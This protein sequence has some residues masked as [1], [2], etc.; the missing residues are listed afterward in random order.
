[1]DWKTLYC[2]NP[3]CPFYGVRFGESRLVKNGTTRGQHQ[4]LC[5]ACGSSIA[6]TYGTPYFDLEHDP[7][8]FEL[9][10]RALAEGNS[11]R[12]TARIIQM[13]KDT[14]CIWLDRAAQQ[15]R[16]V[17]LYLWQQLPL[18]ECQLDELG[19][20]VHTKDEHL[21]WAKTYHDTYGDAWVWV[22]FAPE[23]RLV[24]AFVVGKRTQ[25]DANLL[26]E[27]VAHV[28]TDLIPFFTS[29]QLPEYR[30]ALLHVY[31]R[32]YQPPRCGTRGPHPQPRRVPHKE[33]RYAQVVKTRER[34][35]VVAV[36]HHVVFG[37]VQGIAT[38]LASLPT[39]ATINTS[40]V[41]RENLALRQHN[42]RLTRKTNAFS[43]EL[44]WLEKQ[45]W[46]SLAYTHLVLPHDSLGQ[47]LPMVEPTRGTGSPRRWQ[48]RTPAMAAGLTDHVWT[49]D[50]LLSYR[51]PARFVDQL[52]QLEHLFP[53]PELICQ[54][55]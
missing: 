21:A 4:A 40:F 32:W 35:R 11:I 20:F 31:G 49:T 19:S 28:T 47:A 53:Q 1:M 16:L 42:R 37:D 25:A 34:G 8:L 6:L 27:R 18:R 46:L 12:A 44:P 10:I 39:S 15:C 45:L 54:G 38:L 41:E 33:L 17:I 51:V 43:Q 3:V 14:V 13:D 9:A 50:E 36:D 26:L 23:W 2:P 7:A 22:A 24:V 52:D 5:R 55:N 48:P 30:T 29:D